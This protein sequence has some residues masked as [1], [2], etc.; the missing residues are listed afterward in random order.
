[1]EAS[2]ELELREEEAWQDAPNEPVPTTLLGESLLPFTDT[3]RRGDVCVFVPAHVSQRAFAEATVDS[4]LRLMPG[5]RIAI[6]ADTSE[7]EDYET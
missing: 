7:M 6:A 1:M 5:V 3:L 4:I 2:E